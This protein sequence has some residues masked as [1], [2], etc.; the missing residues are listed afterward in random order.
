MDRKY[1]A[2]SADIVSS[3]SLSREAL[4]EL[5]ARVKTLLG[6][7]A[8]EYPGFWGRLVKGDTIECV[9]EHPGD[10]LRVAV[11]LKSFIKSIVPSDGVADDK[12][13]QF[14]LRL[15]IGI[16]SMRIIDEELDMMDGEAIYLSGRA[17]ANMRD[18]TNDSFQIMMQPD[19]SHGALSV[20]AML[21]NQ[22]INKATRRQCET[23][24]HK[25]QCKVEN[26]VAI[27]MGISRPGV[28]Q[29]L[30]NM[31]W[32][33]IERSIKYFEQLDFGGQQ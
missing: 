8:G 33:A 22:L 28:N 25:L 7:A 2:I 5:T 12:F 1:A 20:I 6:Q 30:R 19:V 18:K 23:L 24:F 13:K 21:L 26:D 3:T 9:M 4:M 31:G 32:D 27:R 17:L 11:L 29:N 14:G 16:G 15:A 10:A